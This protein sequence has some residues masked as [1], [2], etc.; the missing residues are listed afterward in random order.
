MLPRGVLG[1][2]SVFVFILMMCVYVQVT[3][4]DEREQRCWGTKG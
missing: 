3:C 1:F 4:G 2:V